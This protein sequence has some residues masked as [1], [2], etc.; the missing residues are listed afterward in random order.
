ME[1]A[2]NKALNLLTRLK[3]REKSKKLATG[4]LKTIFKYKI[5]K[6]KS[7]FKCDHKKYLIQIKKFLKKFRKVNK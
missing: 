2:E 7:F 3:D 5:Q 4:I 1:N 6:E